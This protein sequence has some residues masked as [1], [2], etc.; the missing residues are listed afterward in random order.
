MQFIVVEAQH[1]NPELAHV[2]LHFNRS[3]TL[4]NIRLLFNLE[5]CVQRAEND[6]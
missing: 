6:V 4:V 3:T 2:L 5:D 1:A